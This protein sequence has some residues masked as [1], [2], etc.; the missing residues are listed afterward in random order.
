MIFG[1]PEGATEIDPEEAHGLIPDITTRAELDQFEA[2][3]IAAADLW[4]GRSRMIRSSL[5]ADSTLRELH[6]QMFRGVWRWAG[7]YRITEKNISASPS[8]ISTRVRQ[9]CDDA[10]A[11]IE[12]NSY[13]PAEIVTRLHHQLVWIHP[14]P[15]GNGR[16]ARLAAD[17][18]ALQL[19][20]PR[21]DWGSTTPETARDSYLAALRQADAGDL[22]PLM[23]FMWRG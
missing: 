15:N 17:L 19:G 20:Q 1:Q 9:L 10:R 5:L 12:F 8:Q 14:F 6:R 18:L 4:A 7:R 21:S 23:A 2:L 13:P 16:H 11:W 22:A 3:N